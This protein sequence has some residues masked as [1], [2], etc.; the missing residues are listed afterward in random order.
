M[1][2]LM[3]NQVD[4]L[5]DLLSSNQLLDAQMYMESMHMPYDVQDKIVGAVSRLKK[6]TPN[7]VAVILEYCK[8]SS[9][10]EQMNH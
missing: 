8:N 7:K 10:P 9:F 5:N 1:N 3:Q 6:I 2:A 4:T